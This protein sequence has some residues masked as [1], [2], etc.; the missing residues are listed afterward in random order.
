ML[1]VFLFL[2]EYETAT[3]YYA[4]AIRIFESVQV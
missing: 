2:Y 1:T 3:F 4:Q